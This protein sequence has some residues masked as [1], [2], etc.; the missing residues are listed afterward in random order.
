MNYNLPTYE[1]CVKICSESN[2]TFYETKFLIDGFNISVFNY[3]LAT[4]QDFVT[5]EAFELRGLTFVFNKDGSLY[6]RYPLLEKFFNLNENVSTLLQSL[7]GKPIKSIFSK[8]DGS[9]IS[10]IKL[11]NGKILAKSKTSFTSDQALLAQQ[12]YETDER[13]N[14]MVNL[15]LTHGLNPIFELVGPKNRIVVSYP[16]EQLILLSIRSKDG[17]YIDINHSG[18][19][20]PISHNLT[21]I[22]LVELKSTINDKEGWVVYFEDGQKIKIKTDWYF[23]LHKIFTD[24]SNREDYLIEMIIEE[25]IDDILSV[26]DYGSDSRNFVEGIVEKTNFKLK[27]MNK[28]IDNLISKFTG[29]KKKFALEFNDNE[30]FGISV[31]IINGG[32]RNDLIKSYVKKKTYRLSQAREWLTI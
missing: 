17:A 14:V 31:K 22:E 27:K 3:R 15:W 23:S 12:I 7:V 19:P 24:Y 16:T 10:F 25:K 28:D 13:I 29:D 20:Q 30:L 18:L 6:Q 2:E 32:D 9:I 5:F 4:Y 11:P 8:E 1:Q 26:M 21:L